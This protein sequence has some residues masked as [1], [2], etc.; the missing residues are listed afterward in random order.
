MLA[1]ALAGH[2]PQLVGAKEA[3]AAGVVG[4]IGARACGPGARRPRQGGARPQRCSGSAA[5]ARLIAAL[6]GT[7]SPAARLAH[8]PTSRPLLASTHPGCLPSAQPA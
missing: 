4:T 7:H 5:C 2:L 6:Q 8:I 3:G 1:S